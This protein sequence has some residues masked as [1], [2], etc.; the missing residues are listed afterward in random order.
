MWAKWKNELKLDRSTSSIWRLPCNTSSKLRIR[1]W[2]ALTNRMQ[3]FTRAQTWGRPPFF[4]VTR[5]LSWGLTWERSSSNRQALIC[6]SSSRI[7]SASTST[8]SKAGSYLLEISKFKLLFTRIEW[9]LSRE[10]MNRLSG[11]VYDFTFF[12]CRYELS[13]DIFD[14]EN[15]KMF[16]SSNLVVKLE[17]QQTGYFEVQ[18]STENGTWLTGSPLKPGNVQIRATLVGTRLNFCPTIA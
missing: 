4:F 6:T 1:C 14:A 12:P 17:F 2:S 13:V 9:N 8:H 3:L 5:M 7:T 15:R 16:P 18:R 11:K 10:W